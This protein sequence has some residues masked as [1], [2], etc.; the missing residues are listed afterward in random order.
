MTCV[1]I[2][3]YNGMFQ[4]SRPCDK[5]KIKLEILVIPVFT[6]TLLTLAFPSEGLWLCWHFAFVCFISA[7]TNENVERGVW[8]WLRSCGK[9][10][11]V[12]RWVV[13][14]FSK[15]QVS[16]KRRWQLVTSQCFLTV[17]DVYSNSGRPEKKRR[18]PTF[19]W[20]KRGRRT[21]SDRIFWLVRTG[22]PVDCV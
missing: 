13:I 2:Y 21:F 17:C 11:C 20:T 22:I 6:L 15:A 12:V 18:V 8:F 5:K 7:V 3:I 14:D 19:A 4:N 10:R 9:R 1:Y 16:S